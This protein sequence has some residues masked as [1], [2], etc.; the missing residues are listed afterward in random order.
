M[1]IL[2]LK[3]KCIFLP[4]YFSVWMGM[5]CPES[6]HVSINYHIHTMMSLS[7]VNGEINYSV[8][9]GKFLLSNGT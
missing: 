2:L 1:L 3:S 9:Q 4:N 6:C 7:M 8:I 5:F